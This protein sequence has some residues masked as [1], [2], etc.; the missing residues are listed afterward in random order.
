MCKRLSRKVDA[1]SDLM[2]YTAI[3][4]WDIQQ[5]RQI[6]QDEALLQVLKK[7]FAGKGPLANYLLE[8]IDQSVDLC[9][10]LEADGFED[11]AP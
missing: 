8:Q 1:L 2:T 6:K 7:E 11:N 9:A 5:T 10:Q 4:S 3:A